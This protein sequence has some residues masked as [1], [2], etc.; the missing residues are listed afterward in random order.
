MTK[1]GLLDTADEIANENDFVCPESVKKE[2][3]Q[4]HNF[5]SNLSNYFN[6][7]PMDSKE[8]SILTTPNKKLIEYSGKKE[9]DYFSKEEVSSLARNLKVIPKQHR[10]SRCRK[11][12]NM[13]SEVTPKKQGRSSLISEEKERNSMDKADSSI[14]SASTPIILPKNYKKCDNTVCNMV[15]TK[16]VTGNSG[17]AKFKIS[18]GD[19]IWLCPLCAFA[20]RRNHY[21]YYCYSI[22]PN[23]DI[24]DDKKWIE[25]DYCRL[26]VRLI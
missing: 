12:K 7:S 19:V 22:Y 10:G 5:Y 13:M 11:G 1:A 24:Q 9:F 14:P 20:F 3:K 25:C 8:N 17:W 4:E 6:F 2:P 23:E 15:S 21:C 26:W 18:N 16:Q